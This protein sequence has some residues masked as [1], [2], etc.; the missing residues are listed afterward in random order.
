MKSLVK[1]ESWDTSQS[2]LFEILVR[3]L[4]RV[5]F[6]VLVEVLVKVN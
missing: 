5:L 2:K 4:V 3:I 6:R 1:K